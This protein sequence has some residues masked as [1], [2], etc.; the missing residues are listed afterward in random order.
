[1]QWPI[2]AHD[3]SHYI[4]FTSSAD[5]LISRTISY[6]LLTGLLVGIFAGVVLLTT[7]VLPFSSPVG[8]AASTLAVVGLFNPLR[9]RL[10][11]IV[12]RRF[13]VP[14]TTRRRQS[15]ALDQPARNAIDL[16]NISRALV[17]VVETSVAPTHTSLWSAPQLHSPTNSLSRTR[18]RGDSGTLAQARDL[19]PGG[20]DFVGI[21]RFQGASP[22]HRVDGSMNP[23]VTRAVIPFAQIVETGQKEITMKS[24]ASIS[25]VFCSGVAVALVAAG[26][27]AASV[28]VNCVK[29]FDLASTYQDLT[30]CKLN[31]VTIPGSDF[32]GTRCSTRTS[33]ARV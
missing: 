33:L 15:S 19:L 20:V 3:F 16:D 1:M 2:A 9:R 21:P 25:F 28:G 13:N 5:R 17:A 23:S 14:A 32:P 11:H 7:R 31:G 18:L 26:S 8:V 24:L 6:V 22:L 10:Q 27:A 12:D 30:N 29:P 4:G